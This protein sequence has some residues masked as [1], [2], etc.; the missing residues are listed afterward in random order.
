MMCLELRFKIELQIYI[1]D[2]AAY[3]L[4]ET[5][6]G[7]KIKALYT[8]INDRSQYW[9]KSLLQGE[10]GYFSPIQQI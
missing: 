3:R 1:G 7:K 2:D 4:F 5:I 10:Q 6:D 9:L 8:T